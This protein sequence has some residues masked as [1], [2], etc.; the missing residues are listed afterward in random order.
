M[1]SVWEWIAQ[2]VTTPL[3]VWALA[4]AAVAWACWRWGRSGRGGLAADIALDVAGHV[5]ALLAARG[6][7]QPRPAP[8]QGRVAVGPVGPVRPLWPPPAAPELVTVPPAT[9]QVMPAVAGPGAV[10]LEP[11]LAE[12]VAARIAQD[13]ELARAMAEHEQVRAEGL[14]AFA[15]LDPD[16]AYDVLPSDDDTPQPDEGEPPPDDPPPPPPAPR[17]ESA[18]EPEPAR[19]AA[20]LPVPRYDWA[21][22]GWTPGSV[23][24]PGL[25]AVAP[26]PWG[27]EWLRQ[28]MAAA[29][30][31]WAGRVR[32]RATRQATRRAERRGETLWAAGELAAA[33]WTA[34]TSVLPTVRAVGQAPVPGVDV[35]GGRHRLADTPP[36]IRAAMVWMTP[37]ERARELVRQCGQAGWWPWADVTDRR[38]RI[39]LRAWAIARRHG[40]PQ[41]LGTFAAPGR[42]P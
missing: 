29:W 35:P 28:R 15:G 20:V 37:A 31:W 23:P 26:G 9:T 11:S 19:Y 33:T 2:P 34:D 12:H 27:S 42:L 30:A 36:S 22:T 24:A 32:H 14:A 25:P 3:P 5:D 6:G 40:L 16:S 41:L 17:P 39:R 1:S 21:R 10:E 7:G 13:P 4:I 8:V 38:T 18:P